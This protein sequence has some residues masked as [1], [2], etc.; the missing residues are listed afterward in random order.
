MTPAEAVMQIIITITMLATCAVFI[1][2]A[3]RP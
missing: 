3:G 2:I 1:H